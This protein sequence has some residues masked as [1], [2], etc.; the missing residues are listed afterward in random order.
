M[1]YELEAGKTKVERFK[2]ERIPHVSIIRESREVALNVE[3]KAGKSYVIVPS[4]KS[5]TEEGIFYLSLYF[6]I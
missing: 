2:K 1:I 5:E 4:C 3:L 6:S